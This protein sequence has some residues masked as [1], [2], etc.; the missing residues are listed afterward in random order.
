MCGVN[1]QG[2]L[3]TQHSAGPGN[4]IIDQHNIKTKQI[5]GNTGGIKII[6]MNSIHSLKTFSLSVKK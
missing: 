2:Q 5:T 4:Y 1:S 3:Q 6:I